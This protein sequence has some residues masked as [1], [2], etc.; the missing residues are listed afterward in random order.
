M[1]AICHIADA[2]QQAR[3]KGRAAF[4][5][6]FTLGYPTQE[7]S[8]SVVEALAGSGADLIELGIPFSDPLADGPTI[9]SSTHTALQQGMTVSRC[10][11]MAQ[12]LRQRGVSQPLL[13]MGYIN[14]IKAYG[15]DRFIQAATQ[16]GVNGLILPDLPMEEGSD[17]E[18]GCQKFG[19]ALVYLVSPTTPLP[20]IK[21]LS[22]HS[23]GFLYLVSVNGVTGVRKSLPVDLEDFVRKVRS[24]TDLPLA[25][26]FGISTP[27]LAVNVGKIA[28][29][30][31]VGSALI[32]AVGKSDH[33]AT[34]AREFISSF[35]TAFDRQSS[36]LGRSG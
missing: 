27:E 19:L 36:P 23:T 7:D 35:I 10:L 16:A 34:T 17:I 1:N 21:L 4:M 25:V 6:Y 15:I 30:V 33:P 13:F 22:S 24:E 3:A 14:P 5:P 18:A 32:D 26:G 2:F 12:V 11:E 9:Q 29:G 8:L 28:D 31:I 20:R